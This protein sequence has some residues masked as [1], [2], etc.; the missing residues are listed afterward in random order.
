MS[1]VAH[2]ADVTFFTCLLFVRQ[3]LIVEFSNKLRAELLQH[4]LVLAYSHSA[5]VLFVL[6]TRMNNTDNKKTLF[7]FLLNRRVFQ[8]LN[9]RSILLLCSIVVFLNAQSMF[10]LKKQ[11]RFDSSA[12]LWLYIY[13]TTVL[14]YY[15]NEKVSV[16]LSLNHAK[17]SGPRFNWHFA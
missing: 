12:Y 6:F 15:K 17:T 14:L 16:C 5:G 3:L 10:S 1:D 2:S 11:N 8:F 9:C 13:P 7:V 4:F